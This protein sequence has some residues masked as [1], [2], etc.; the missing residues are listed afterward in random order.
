MPVAI[1]DDMAADINAAG[2]NNIEAGVNSGNLVLRE[3][4]G[5]SITIVNTLLIRTTITLQV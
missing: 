2:I 3:M 5:G 4:S 1:A